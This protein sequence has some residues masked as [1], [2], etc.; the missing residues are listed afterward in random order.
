[1][2]FPGCRHT[3]GR[4]PDRPKKTAACSSVHPG[5]ALPPPFPA[6]PL[7]RLLLSPPRLLEPGARPRGRPCT[8][9]NTAIPATSHPPSPSH[10][11]TP[12]PH[13]VPHPVTPTPSPPPRHPHPV[14]PTQSPSQSHLVALEQRLLV[15]P[16]LGHVL[17]HLRGRWGGG[18]GRRRGLQGCFEKR[19]RMHWGGGGTKAFVPDVC[20]CVGRCA[21]KR[22]V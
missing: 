21:D 14:T 12:V 3:H 1:M 20:A 9:A 7:R 18:G 2:C 11:Y 17:G 13:P 22:G 10:T 6:F 5:H 16:Q 4:R 15:V 19:Y 8:L